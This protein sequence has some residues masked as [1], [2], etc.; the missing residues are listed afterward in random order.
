MQRIVVV[1]GSVAAARVLDTL[2]RLRTDAEVVLMTAERRFPAHDPPA[3]SKQVLSGEWQ[4]DEAL[5]RVE[6]PP[7]TRVLTQT[8]AVAVDL[9]EHVIR[10]DRGDRVGYDRLVVATGSRPRPHGLVPRGVRGVYE[11]RTAH[12]SLALREELR[13][14]RRLLVVG[15]GLIGCEVAATA[16][17]RGMDVT[18]IDPGSRPLLRMAGP[19]AGRFIAGVHDEMGV[20]LRFGTGVEKI[21]GDERVSGVQLTDG[22]HIQGDA[23][24]VGIGAV[25]NT[26][27]LSGTGLSIDDGVSCDQTCTALGAPDVMV[28][29]DACRWPSVQFGRSMRVEHWTNAVEQGS[30][31]GRAITLDHARRPTFDSVPYA[32]SDQFGMKIQ[33]LGVMEGTWRVLVDDR[34][35]RRFLALC[36]IDDVVRGVVA[37]N[38][39]HLIAR[40]RAAILRGRHAGTPDWAWAGEPLAG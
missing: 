28:A 23:V 27:L 12:H 2:A 36:A 35:N 10:T 18:V 31:V 3:L 4:L 21:T 25:P 6:P 7:G 22:R 37:V 20:D 33:A 17:V 11:L 13:A 32:W 19:E 38:N 16:R 30:H 40:A 1:G 14:G 5:L 39:P 34:V 15:G 9:A 8:T 29:G 26:E 24:V